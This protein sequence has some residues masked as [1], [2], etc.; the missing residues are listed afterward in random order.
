MCL[1]NYNRILVAD[2]GNNR[3]LRFTVGQR[4]G[5]IIAG[6]SGRG[7]QLNQL[8]YP[9]SITIDTEGRVIISDTG[10]NRVLRFTIGITEGEIISQEHVFDNPSSIII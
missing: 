4:N 7:N 10:N 6:G 1:D 9:K 5:E 3:V 2:T 8:M